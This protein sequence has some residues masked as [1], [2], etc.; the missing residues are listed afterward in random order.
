MLQLKKLWISLCMIFFLFSC[1]TDE[2]VSP[3]TQEPAGPIPIALSELEVTTNPSTFQSAR[4]VDPANASQIWRSNYT[5]DPESNFYRE[6][7]IVFESFESEDVLFE[8]TVQRQGTNFIYLA[9]LNRPGFRLA[10]PT[11]DAGGRTQAWFADNNSDG[12]VRWRFF[13]Y[14]DCDNDQ[15]APYVGPKFNNSNFIAAYNE[16]VDGNYSFF[17]Y[18]SQFPVS[19]IDTWG[20]MNTSFSFIDGCDETFTIT[21]S[22]APGTIF[23]G[24]ANV[25]TT[26][27]VQDI[28]GNET[29]LQ[30]VVKLRN[31][32]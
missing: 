19:F 28:N 18:R 12:W 5:G 3:E 14:T 22:P 2:E 16:L 6:G 27:R 32:P 26:L 13:I 10:L 29:V 9:D 11:W 1:S 24:P 31:S 23:N 17:N 20:F 21:Q 7:N 4:Q 25:N 8:F 15:S 30:Y